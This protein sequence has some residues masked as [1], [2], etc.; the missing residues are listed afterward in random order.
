MDQLRK[1]LKRMGLRRRD[2]NGQTSFEEVEAAIKKEREVSG[3]CIDYRILHKRLK[4]KHSLRVGRNVVMMLSALDNPEG[5]AA[6]KGKK[7]KRRI[8]HSKGPDY[9]W[10]CDGYDKWFCHTWL[11]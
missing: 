9:I 3:N 6:R 1:R 10:H 11:H 7:L 2:K 8:Y 5:A 4:E